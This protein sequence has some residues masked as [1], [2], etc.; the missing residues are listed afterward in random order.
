LPGEGYQVVIGLYDPDTGQR[1]IVP[2]NPVNEVK[3]LDVELH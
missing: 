1:L 2:G 3:L